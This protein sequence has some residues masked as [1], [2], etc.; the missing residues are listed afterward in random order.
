MASAAFIASFDLSLRGGVCALLLLIAAALVRDHGRDIAGRLG[1]LFALG[2]VAHTITSTSGFRAELGWWAPPMLALANGDNLIF[3]LFARALFDDNFKARP[4]HAA[5]WAGIVAVSLVEC[6]VLRPSRS[7]LAGPIDIALTLMALGF[8]LLAAA[9]TLA[10]WRADLIE[11]RRRLRLFIVI[12]SAIYTA[13]T[14]LSRLRAGQG[15]PPPSADLAGAFGLAL[16][17]GAVAWS[18]LKVSDQAGLFS[19]QV[20]V[21]AANDVFASAPTDG[22]S[23]VDRELVAALQHA[24]SYDRA[25]RREGLT[26]GELATLQGLPE[27]RLR[28][29]INQ[30]LGHRNFNS[31]LNLYRIADA[32]AALADSSQAGVSILTI[33]LDAGFNSLGPFNRAFKAETG[34]TPTEYRRTHGG[35]AGFPI[36]DFKIGEAV[37]V[38]A[39]PSS[40]LA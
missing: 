7:P 4:W 24:M 8:A 28:R 21:S 25:Y 31:F 35:E 16:I 34:L 13:L 2:A 29:L 26:I 9:Q 33:A 23:P 20:H 5:A 37:S 22:L 40:N 17:A 30:G 3:W 36:A 27:Y 6:L 1:A 32:K 39:R 11:Q 15:V 38:S 14:A 19:R 10:S 18:Q 12:G